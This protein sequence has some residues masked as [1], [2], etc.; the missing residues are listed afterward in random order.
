MKARHC[1]KTKDRILATALD[2]FNEQGTAAVSTNHI[3]EAMGISPGNLYYHFPNKTA[4]IRALF[5]QQFD[6]ADQI[7]DLPTDRLPT[8]ADVAALIRANFAMLYRYRFI[9]REMLALLRADAELHQRYL[10]VRQRGYDGFFALIEAF[11]AADV[12]HGLDATAT[13]QLAEL[14][15]LISEHWPESLEMRSRP[16]DEQTMQAGVDL[17]LAVLRPYLK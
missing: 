12:M 10:V 6:H 11:Q 16:I 8:L 4:I 13:A 15:W 9:Y 1:M 17:M 14:C 3:A 2:L 5:E 7:F